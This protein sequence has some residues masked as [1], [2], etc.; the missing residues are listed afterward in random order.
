[1]RK[2]IS[3][4]AVAG[5]ALAAACH[6]EPPPETVPIQ[7]TDP[8]PKVAAQNI[9]NQ[10]SIDAVTRSADSA[11]WQHQMAV[12]EQAYAD[13]VAKARL[14]FEAAGNNGASQA[15]AKNAELRS[16]LGMMVHF[17]VG[18][19][20]LEGDA[21]STLDRK[22]AILMANPAVR[23][24][25]TGAC[26]ERGSNQ[27]NEALGERRAAA[28]SRYL[29]GKGINVARLDRISTGENAPIDAGDTEAAWAQNRRA[30]FTILGSDVEL[31]LNQ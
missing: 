20:Q 2:T 14:A 11:A 23:L 31:S 18:Q 3:L 24:K 5:L 13:S 28:V 1:M 15:A 7:T 27:Y 16:E 22:V 30:E 8:T 17:E 26:D 12:A 29:V 19:A 25:I 10:D 9:F 6:R 4:I 21:R